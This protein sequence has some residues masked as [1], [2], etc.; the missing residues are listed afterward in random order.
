MRNYVYTVYHG[1]E[2]ELRDT[3]DDHYYL[4]YR[5]RYRPDESFFPSE[6]A[7]HVFKKLIKKNL[8]NSAFSVTTYA[9][10]NGHKWQVDRK[11]NNKLRLSIGEPVDVPELKMVSQGWY[12]IWV[13]GSEIDKVWEEREQSG[14]PL[15]FPENLPK[16][17]ELSIDDL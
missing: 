14:Y 16:Y 2:L 5:G 7:A 9:S 8:V 17:V 15:P 11:E 12:E 13:D 3:D 6:M 10:Y 1:Q 4:I